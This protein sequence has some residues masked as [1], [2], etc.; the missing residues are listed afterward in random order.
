MRF[1]LFF[2]I[3]LGWMVLFWGCAYNAVHDFDSEHCKTDF[4]GFPDIPGW[5]HNFIPMDAA[6]SGTRE[7]YFFEE[8][9]GMVLTNNS[10]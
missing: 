3:F 6:I 10:I 1:Y 2:T 8:E 4:T 9:K 5:K 7:F